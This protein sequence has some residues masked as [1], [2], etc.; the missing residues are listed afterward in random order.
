MTDQPPKL[1]LAINR[2]VL[3]YSPKSHV[4]F[5]YRPT[6]S[7]DEYLL[8]CCD[9]VWNLMT[10]RA[11]PSMERALEVAERFFATASRDWVIAPTQIEPWRAPS[12]KVFEDRRLSALEVLRRRI[13]KD[14][15]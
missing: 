6:R 7:S 1:R 15:D 9:E 14:V 8:S 12:G 13:A 4:R 2:F 10:D 5:D 11:F 3:A